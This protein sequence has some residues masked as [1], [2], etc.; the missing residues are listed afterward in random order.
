MAGE[1]TLLRLLPGAVLGIVPGL[2][3]LLW[4]SA[5]AARLADELVRFF[6]FDED[7]S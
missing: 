5:D 1:R 7:A 4:L 3:L 6:T 2:W